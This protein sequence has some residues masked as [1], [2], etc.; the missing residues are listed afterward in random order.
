MNKITLYAEYHDGSWQGYSDMQNG[1]R[2]YGVGE[3]KEL[4]AQDIKACIADYQKHEGKDDV[5][6]SAI[7]LNTVEFETLEAN[8]K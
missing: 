3:T 1:W 7:D 8:K 6:W 2:A 4:F 5:Y